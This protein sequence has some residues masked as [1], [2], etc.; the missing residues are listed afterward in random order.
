[1]TTGEIDV[2]DLEYPEPDCSLCGETTTFDDG[3]Y[4]CYSCELSWD[5]MTHNFSGNTNEHRC[6]EIR[7]CDSSRCVMSIDHQN[8]II[9]HLYEKNL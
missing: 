7:E 4:F 6:T 9:G 2:P 5:A 3:H 1:M 8:P